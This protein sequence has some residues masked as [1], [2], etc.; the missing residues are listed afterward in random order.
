MKIKTKLRGGPTRG[1]GSVPV[2]IA[3]S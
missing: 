2:I 1:C 3:A